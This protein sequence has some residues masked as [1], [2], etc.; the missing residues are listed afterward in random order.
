MYAL[1]LV[2]YELS[3]RRHAYANDTHFQVRLVQEF[4]PDPGPADLGLGQDL[5]PGLY[6]EY[7]TTAG[8]VLL[9][10]PGTGPRQAANT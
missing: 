2:K 6:G 5:F 1:G 9:E 10:L 3:C 7:G 4:V 8:L